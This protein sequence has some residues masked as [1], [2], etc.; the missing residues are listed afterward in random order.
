[1]ENNPNDKSLMEHGF[2]PEQ[3]ERL[4]RFRSIQ[5]ERARLQFA[6][7][8]HRLEF[9]RW[10]VVTGRITDDLPRLAEQHSSRP[11]KA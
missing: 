7:E 3:I 10:L 9:A 6:M 8:R 5:A 4:Y 1:M 2:A 11:G